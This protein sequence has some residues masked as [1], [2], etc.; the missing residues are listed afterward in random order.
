MPLHLFFLNLLVCITTVTMAMIYLRATMRSV[1]LELCGTRT[2]ADFWLKSTDILAYS[3]AL[4][5]V[6]IFD[7]PHTD[8]PGDT[9]RLSLIL[10][11][12]GIFLTVAFVSKSIWRR[13]A[14]IPGAQS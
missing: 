4:M 6:L 11:L 12:A 9:I 7:S 10:S 5:L 3:G 13:V 14:N 1:I 8:S 2:A